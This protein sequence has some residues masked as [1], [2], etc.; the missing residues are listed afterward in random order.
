MSTKHFRLARLC[1]PMTLAALLFAGCG[2]DNKASDATETPSTDDAKAQALAEYCAQ[3]DEARK[4]DLETADGIKQ[5]LKNLRSVEAA[6]PADLVDDF[7]AAIPLLESIELTF[8]AN[9]NGAAS[10]D[11]A[12]SPYQVFL[13]EHPEA[14]AANEAISA[15]LGDACGGGSGTETPGRNGGESTASAD[16]AKADYCA[17]LAADGTPDLESAD[18]LSAAL[19]RLSLLQPAVPADLATDFSTTLALF[20]AKA[21]SFTQFGDTPDAL[22]ADGSPYATFID[23]NPDAKGSVTRITE[24]AAGVCG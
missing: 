3:P 14:K 17:Q 2:S 21:A 16:Q 12:T 22:T 7:N 10:L 18:G 1:A 20:T 11:D 6:V 9:G 8:I 5:K 19:N 13:A 24:W 23:Q 4:P 15:W